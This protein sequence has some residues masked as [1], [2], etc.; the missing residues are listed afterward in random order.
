MSSRPFACSAL[1]LAALWAAGCGALDPSWHYPALQDPDI[2]NRRDENGPPPVE[3]PA[4]AFPATELEWQTKW[5]RCP[6]CFGTGRERDFSRHRHARTGTSPAT[7]PCPKC[8]GMGQKRE[9][10]LVETDTHPNGIKIER[11]L[12]HS[13]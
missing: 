5:V 1:L 11:I 3:N 7:G 13:R 9:R 12:L 6:R 2:Q 8:N 10:C 4:L